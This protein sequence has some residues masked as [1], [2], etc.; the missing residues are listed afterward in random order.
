MRKLLFF[1]V[2]T[3]YYPLALLVLFSF[4]G[5][6]SLSHLISIAVGYGF[7]YGYLDRLK[8]S[9]SRCKSW[10]ESF[11]ESL[12]QQDGWILA[13]AALGSS[14]WSEEMM[15]Q[16]STNSGGGL[17]NMFFGLT[18]SM[19]QQQQQQLRQSQ[20]NLGVGSSVGIGT[21]DPRSGRVI[22]PHSKPISM[23]TIPSSTTTKL[24]TTGGRQ[25]GGP[26]RRPN[27]DPR[28][29]RLKAIERRMVGSSNEHDQPV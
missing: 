24:P 11:L 8:I 27:T 3:I 20:G 18:S 2:P 12:T 15:V 19:Q 22:K 14:A 1:T 13:N 26:S 17:G 23:D 5:G 28:Q 4:I 16:G 25:L 9:D 7:G 10:E 6:F 29:Q 21:D